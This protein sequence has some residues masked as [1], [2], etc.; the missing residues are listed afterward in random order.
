MGIFKA[1]GL[2]SLFPV[3]PFKVK[4]FRKLLVIQIC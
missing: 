1:Y 2:E 3:N 4:A